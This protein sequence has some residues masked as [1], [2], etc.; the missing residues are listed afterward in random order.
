MKQLLPK[1]NRQESEGTVMGVET[2][3]QQQYGT[4]NALNELIALVPTMTRASATLGA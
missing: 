2:S 3:N 1:I 4:D